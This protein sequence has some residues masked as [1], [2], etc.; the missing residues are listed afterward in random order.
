MM[1]NEEGMVKLVL[2]QLNGAEW[3]AHKEDDFPKFR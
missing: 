3:S 1:L 2:S